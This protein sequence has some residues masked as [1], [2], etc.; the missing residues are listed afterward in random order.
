MGTVDLHYKI[1]TAVIVL[2]IMERIQ[3]KLQ[4]Y[5][6]PENNFLENLEMVTSMSTFFM[7]TIFT[8]EDDEVSRINDLVF[9]V[10]LG[11]NFRFILM[12]TYHMCKLYTRF[13]IIRKLSSMLATVLLIKKENYTQVEEPNT[14][15]KQKKKSKN[16]QGS[17]FNFIS[18]YE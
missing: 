3:H 7:A 10:L 15:V 6:E 8:N 18:F 1:I 9:I 14:T 12:W 11:L 13:K 17:F 2:L 5:K 16:H 4:P